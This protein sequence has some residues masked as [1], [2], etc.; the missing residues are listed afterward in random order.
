[1]A[2]LVT[3]ELKLSPNCEFAMRI[4]KSKTGFDVWKL[5]KWQKH[6]TVNFEENESKESASEFL[7]DP[8]SFAWS[9]NARFLAVLFK[10]QSKCV[11]MLYHLTSGQQT[12][13]VTSQNN[14][15]EF[16]CL[17]D[18]TVAYL[19]TPD[20]TLNLQELREAEEKG[21]EY[22]PVYKHTLFTCKE[23]QITQFDPFDAASARITAH[24]LSFE[25]KISLSH[26]VKKNK[27]PGSCNHYTFQLRYGT[28]IELR[29]TISHDTYSL[30]P[31]QASPDGTQIA[32]AAIQIIDSPTTTPNVFLK[33]SLTRKAMFFLKDPSTGRRIEKYKNMMECNLHANDHVILKWLT[34]KIIITHMHW[35]EENRKYSLVVLDIELGHTKDVYLNNPSTDLAGIQT[36]DGSFFCVSWCT[37]TRYKVDPG[38]LVFSLEVIETTEK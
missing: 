5:E 17:N 35:S 15:P 34:D 24:A 27:E 26:S 2:Q 33:D 10:L 19:T 11:I 9:Q 6:C 3:R 16:A 1:M 21:E 22:N 23:G 32:F 4:N 18:G 36:C 30:W 8:F 37:I 28:G 29:H 14:I 12:K 7:K 20:T 38:S 13:V 31:G 25:I